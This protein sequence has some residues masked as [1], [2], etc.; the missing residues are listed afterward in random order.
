MQTLRNNRE[1]VFGPRIWR[2]TLQNIDQQ[3]PCVEMIGT[4]IPGV[5]WGKRSESV[6]FR[7]D[8]G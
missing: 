2:N 7:A 6:V 3:D 1:A 8:Q 5:E 4:V